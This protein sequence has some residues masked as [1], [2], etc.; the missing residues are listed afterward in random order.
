MTDSTSGTENSL[1]DWWQV[2][3]RGTGVNSGT[4]S[5]Q[6]IMDVESRY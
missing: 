3:R 4:V 5:Q 2:I 1:D 6:Y